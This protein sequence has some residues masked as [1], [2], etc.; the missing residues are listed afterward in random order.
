MAFTAQNPPRLWKRYVDDTFIMQYAEHNKQLFH[1]INNIDSTI[2][3]SIK[4]TRE[5][6]F[7]PFVD[8]LVTQGQ[9]GT[10]LTKY[11]IINSLANRAKTVSL[12]PQHF[13]T[14]L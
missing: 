5:N 4:A 13:R 3:F 9:T 7:I 2:K 11:C 14:E 6:D 1:Y 12:I 10:A 8:I